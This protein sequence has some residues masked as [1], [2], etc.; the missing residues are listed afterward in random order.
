MT[1]P[2]ERGGAWAEH[3]RTFNRHGGIRGLTDE[4]DALRAQLD[5]AN[6]QIDRMQRVVEAARE[7]AAKDYGEIEEFDAGVEIIEA[8]VA[9]AALDQQAQ[10]AKA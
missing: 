6:A 4:I 8:L 3:V 2:Q 1:D 10:T 7:W 9:L 5:Q